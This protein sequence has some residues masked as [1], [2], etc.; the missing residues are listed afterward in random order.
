MKVAVVGAGRLGTAVAVA[1]RRARHRIV[2]VAGRAETHGRAHAH[3]P[4]VPVGEPAVVATEADLVIV[5]TPDDLVEPTVCALAD[6]GAVGSGSWVAHL[7]GALGLDVLEAARSAGA[8][9]LAIH[10]LQTFPD[11]ASAIDGLPGCAIAVTADDEEGYGLG[12]R[13]AV[14]LGGVSFRLADEMRP[15]YHAAAVFA[16]N[17]LIAASAIGESL[18]EL[19]GVPDAAGAMAPLQRA[20]LDHVERLGAVGALTGPAVRG[21]VGTLE[22]NLDALRRHAPRLVGPYVAMARATVELA[23]RSGR[24]DAASRDAVEDL[25]ARWS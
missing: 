14:D 15:L 6:A 8:R 17:Y 19:A 16:S 22:R 11:V 23:E 13:L 3:L 24:L 18:F 25:L 4:D 21:D 7:S 12:E 5:G 10:P 1:L 2:G 9:V 20:S